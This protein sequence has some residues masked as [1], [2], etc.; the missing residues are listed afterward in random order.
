MKTMYVGVDREEKYP[1]E[2]KLAIFVEGIGMGIALAMSFVL[3][4]GK[5][6]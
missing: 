6:L 2:K 1:T 4:I 3:L 5:I